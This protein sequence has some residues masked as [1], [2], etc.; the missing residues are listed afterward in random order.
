M[1]FRKEKALCPAAISRHD[2]GSQFGITAPLSESDFARGEWF[3]RRDD[4]N[5]E[6]T[7]RGQDERAIS[8]ELAEARGGRRP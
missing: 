1:T 3:S 4:H 2:L 8:R 7:V 5:L 6:E